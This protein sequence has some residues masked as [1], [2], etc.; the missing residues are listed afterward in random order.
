MKSAGKDFIDKGKDVHEKINQNQK[1]L[2]DIFDKA[3]KS[4][5]KEKYKEQIEK[6]KKKKKSK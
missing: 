2:K 6:K 5:V 1:E 4:D 3:I